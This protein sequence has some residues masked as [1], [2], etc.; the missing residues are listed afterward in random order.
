RLL[1]RAAGARAEA[2]SALAPE[3]SRTTRTTGRLTRTSRRRIPHRTWTLRLSG[4]DEDAD[5]RPVRRL[6]VDRAGAHGQRAFPERHPRAGAAGPRQQGRAVSAARRPAPGRALPERGQ[7][8]VRRDP[9]SAARA[10]VQ[11]PGAAGARAGLQVVDRTWALTNSCTGGSRN[12]D[13]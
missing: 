7:C 8:E 12:H 2:R 10:D 6:D 1:V 9:G 3:R 11:P 13:Q 5:A 4:G